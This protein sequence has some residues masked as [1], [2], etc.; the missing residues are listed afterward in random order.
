MLSRGSLGHLAFPLWPLHSA[1]GA[2]RRKV[3]A[4]PPSAS[5][6]CA[7]RRPRTDCAYQGGSTTCR[8]QAGGL[9]HEPQHFNAIAESIRFRYLARERDAGEKNAIKL[10]AEDLAVTFKEVNPSFD[11]GRFLTACGIE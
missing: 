11:R 2:D 4:L 5:L 7:S 8:A 3:A 6:R 9:S 1:L 10:V